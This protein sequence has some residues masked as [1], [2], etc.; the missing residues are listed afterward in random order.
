MSNQDEARI[1]KLKLALVVCA[2]AALVSALTAVRYRLQN[3]DLRQGYALKLSAVGE[4]L[5]N[6]DL[7]FT[8][9]D[10]EVDEVG[11]KELPAQQGYHF[12]IVDM[13]ITNKSSDKKSFLPQIQTFLKDDKGNK[14]EPVAAP[15]I[16]SASPAGEIIA[17]DKSSGKV[18]YSIPK[19][20][21]A[22]R[23]YFEPTT[24]PDSN[25]IVID[26]TDKML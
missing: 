1:K 4:V 18:G 5:E 26:L 10:V 2:V 15:S 8:I 7:R 19:D 24:F 20:A 9:N 16:V 11:V 22:V 13:S 14:Y 25:T 12:V 3:I 23:F 17:G 6:K 21:T